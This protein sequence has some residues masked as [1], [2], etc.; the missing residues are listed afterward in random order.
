MTIIFI[1][2]QTVIPHHTH[3]I[4]LQVLVALPA[5]DEWNLP[6]ISLC[7][8]VRTCLALFFSEFKEIRDFSADT[9]AVPPKLPKF[10]KILKF[11]PSFRAERENHNQIISLQVGISEAN[12]PRPKRKSPRPTCGKSEP[13]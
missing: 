6:L 10:S 11:P 2:Y 7:C 5:C 13:F 8:Q 1:N 4:G 12:P 9:K 3:D